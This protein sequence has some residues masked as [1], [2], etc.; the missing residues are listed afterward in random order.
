[1]R[2]GDACVAHGGRSNVTGDW[3][4]GDA[5]VPSPTETKALPK[6]HDKIPTS[7]S[8]TPDGIRKQAEIEL[9]EEI[10]YHPGRLEKLLDFYSY[11]GYIGHKVHLLVAYDLEWD[12]LEMED[13]EEI[14]VYTFTLDEALAATMV[15]Y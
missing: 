15:D 11:P 9:R 13:G 6:S 3:D 14:R 12:P 2:G 7:E 1:M 4:E 8:P 5:S 10:G